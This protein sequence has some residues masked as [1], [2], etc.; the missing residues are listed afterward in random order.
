MRMMSSKARELS[1]EEY[2]RKLLSYGGFLGAR[3][4]KMVIDD[5]LFIVTEFRGGTREIVLSPDGRSIT[6]LYRKNIMKEDGMEYVQREADGFVTN[7]IGADKYIEERDEIDK[8][9][10]RTIIGRAYEKY[11]KEGGFQPDPSKDGPE[12]IDLTGLITE[13]DEED[14]LARYEA[15]IRRLK[16]KLARFEAE[17]RKPEK[18]TDIRSMK[19]PSEKSK[20]PTWE[21]LEEHL[22]EY[23]REKKKMLESVESELQE[24][25]IIRKKLKSDL[26][27]HKERHGNARFGPHNR[28]LDADSFEKKKDKD[29]SH[30]S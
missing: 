2:R 1:D 17:R 23:E 9:W 22:D 18:N 24:Y 15:R 30:R 11:W 6:R 4:R 5:N 21:I 8:K 7:G 12:V 16:E 29:P 10:N 3:T 25:E 26:E 28:V 14:K 13:A 20:S 19:K 27:R